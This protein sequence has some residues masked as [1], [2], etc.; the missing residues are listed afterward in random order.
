MVTTRREFIG[1]AAGF[2]V[3][4]GAGVP[5]LQACGGDDDTGGGAV[6]DAIDDG[7]EPE[8]G[9][10]RVY[11]YADYVNPDTVAAFEAQYG[12]TV[13]IT[14]F[15]VDAEAITKLANGSVDVDV[16]NSAAPNTLDRLIA[17]GLLQP[18]NKSYL[19]NFSN[20]LPSFTS[21]WYDEGSTYT[22]PYTVFSSGIAYR[23]DRIDPAK[24]EEMGWDILW[25]PAHQ[26][27]TSILDDYRE[28]ISMALLRR[29]ITDVNTTDTA[30]I[31]QAGADLAE[32]VDLM[33]IKVNIEAYKDIP[34][35]ATDLA[36]TWSGDM[37]AGVWYMP[38]GT[39]ASVLGWWYPP[40]GVGV[41][42]NDCMA[43]TASAK[44]PVLAHLWIN[45]LLDAANAEEN[46][47]W[48]GYLPPI[49]GLDADYL[50]EN[51]YAPENL[52]SAVLTDDIIGKGLRFEP[53]DT[54]TDR[55]WEETWSRFTA[56]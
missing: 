22:V 3:M 49:Q 19:T 28:G 24:V 51:E 34:E 23:S 41:V 2:G 1:H 54:D 47:G 15:D 14:T 43:V 27:V 52:R 4:L 46:F 31:E 10:L 21:P 44:N 30:Q 7:L 38:E 18:L 39:D 42:N 5:L 8:A 56:G 50:I 13:E 33:N 36:H 37:L 17:G 11:N 35:G 26:G 16:H 53:L 9:P 25:D 12:V 55:V 40:D 20:V 48:N 45:F 6:T 29:G 32:L